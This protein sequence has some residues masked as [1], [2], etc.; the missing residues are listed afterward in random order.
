MASC[1]PWNRL[2]S[3]TCVSLSTGPM[4]QPI[5]IHSTMTTLMMMP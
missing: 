1:S 3:G 5:A 2:N 4:A